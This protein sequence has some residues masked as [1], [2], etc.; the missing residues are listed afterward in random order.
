MPQYEDETIREILTSVR[1]IALVGAS[2]DPSRP[3]N[4]V[5]RFLLDHGYDVYPVNPLPSLTEIHGRKVYPRVEDVPVPVD[6]VDVFRVSEWAGAACDDA[7][8]A[9]ARVVWMQLG[10]IN[11][12]GKDRAEAAGLQVIMDRCPKI[13]IRRLSLPSIKA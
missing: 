13:E 2:P 9:K 12:E 11:E 10:V 1:T 5:M 6:M 8:A 3:S 4:D 7:I